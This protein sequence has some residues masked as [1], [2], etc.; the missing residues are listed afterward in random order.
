MNHQDK[1]VIIVGAG[2]FGLSTAL[3]MSR[4]G[5]KDITIFDLQPYHENSYDPAQGCDAASA[6]VNKIYRCSY[7][8]EIEYQNLALS[9]R[10]VWQSWN[11]Q[12]AS[13]SQTDLPPALT[14]KTQLY[15]NN[16]FLRISTHSELSEYDNVSLEYLEK[17]DLRKYQTVRTNKEDRARLAKLDKEQPG[18]N[19]MHKLDLFKDRL[20]PDNGKPLDGFLDVTGGF[21]RADKACAWVLHLCKKAGVKFV[22]GKQ[23]GKL[24]KLL[25]EKDSSGG[26]V[27]KGI[28]TAD[29][30]QHLGDLVIVAAGGWTPSIV[31]DMN[32]LLETTAG[33]VA[34]V[35]LPKNR[36]DL[37]DKYS[38]EKFPALAFGLTGHNSPVYGGLYGFPRTEDGLIK[39]GY[40]G[41]KWTNY[42]TSP[43]N[44]Q[45]VSMPRTAFS[46]DPI[47]HVP[48]LAIDSLRTFIET[49]W[50]DLTEL[51]ITKTRL[52]WYTDSNDNNFVIDYVPGY[53]K[54]LFVCSGGS[55]H[56]FKFLPV[57][58]DHVVNQVEGKQDQF[59]NLWKYRKPSETETHVNGL[60]EGEA[61]DRVLAK[62]QLAQNEDWTWKEK[63]LE[64]I[65]SLSNAVRAK[66]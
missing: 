66:L 54:S 14:P 63:A 43:I 56:G 22:L 12:I 55:G 3:H 16:G 11:D 35:Q 62:L 31:P 10:K 61:G 52:C 36:P 64:T 40:R 39:I 34:T 57:L 29:G 20:D 42:E 51:G 23:E 9:G 6:D 27:M 37:W 53:N 26:K 60:D 17:A 4:R 44:G 46:D 19:W 24:S 18:Q 21:T 58:G 28:Q 7:G 65:E 32:R 2:V 38:P 47:H 48:K 30:K 41:R 25:E 45:R 33:S 8:E 1:K 5:Y 15:V 49:F 59:T 50:S 13:S